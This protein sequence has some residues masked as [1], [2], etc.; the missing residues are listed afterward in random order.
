MAVLQQEVIQ[1]LQAGETIIHVMPDGEGHKRRDGQKP[2]HYLS[3][4]GRVTDAT[5]EKLKPRMK[6]VSKGLFEDIDPQEWG[7][8]GG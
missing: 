1:R 6:P 8:A 7:W 3:G 2:I 5:Y 4:G